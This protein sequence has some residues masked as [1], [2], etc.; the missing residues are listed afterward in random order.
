MFEENPVGQAGDEMGK[1]RV[2]PITE[3]RARG[4]KM[5]C[6]PTEESESPHGLSRGFF[7]GPIGSCFLRP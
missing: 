4:S 2:N 7:A 5:A 3:P 6:Q 1:G